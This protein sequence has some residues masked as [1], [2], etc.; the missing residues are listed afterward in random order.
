MAKTWNN[1]GNQ[2]YK[3]PTK[4]NGFSL[5]KNK[6]F[7]LGIQLIPTLPILHIFCLVFS[8]QADDIIFIYLCIPILL[9]HVMHII[10]D[11]MA[12]LTVFSGI[13]I[14]PTIINVDGRI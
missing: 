7:S 3:L 5:L 10:V 12:T 11:T 4:M 13:L 2:K 9:I 8:M 14:L 6:L 1:I